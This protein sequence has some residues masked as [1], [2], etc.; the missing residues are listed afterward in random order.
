MLET[1]PAPNARAARML[2]LLRDW[3]ARGASRIDRGL[4]GKID[5]PG[6]AIM[7][8]AWPR[9]ADAVMG[10]VLG[11]QLDALARLVAPRPERPQLG[12][13]YGDGWYGYVDKDL[14][15]LRGRRVRGPFRT[16]FCGAGNLGACRAAL[17]A[18]LDA[19]GAELAAAQGP[20]PNGWRADATG[21]ADRLRAGPARRAAEDALDQ[22]ADV[23]A[24]RVLPGTPLSRELRWLL[25]RLRRRSR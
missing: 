9:I 1:G 19:A 17:W 18:A 11:P 7:D 12:S 2:K 20:N 3:R 13:S 24:G 22:P 6:A 8:A 16:R 15:R 23:P 10:P 5:H 14:R 21:R 4:D 25:R